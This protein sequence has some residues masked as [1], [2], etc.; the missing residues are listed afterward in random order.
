MLKLKLQYFGHLMW[1]TDSLEKTLMLGEIEGKRRRGQQR[2]NWLDGITSS[3][4][5]SLSK[6]REMMKDREAWR[7]AVHGSQRVGHDQTTEQQKET[8][9]FISGLS[10]LFHQSVHLS[11]CIVFSVV[12]TCICVFLMTNNCPRSSFLP[13]PVNPFP[14]S[15]ELTTVLISCF[16]FVFLPYISLCCS[17]TLYKRNHTV[18]TYLV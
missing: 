8:Y 18:C 12:L 4:D 3:M 1:R 17:R 15:L 6:L 9:G 5:I 10:I 7:G 14:Y 16:F 2:M 13:F 11:F